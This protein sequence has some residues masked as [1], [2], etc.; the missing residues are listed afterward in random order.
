MNR[1]PVPIESVAA[2]LMIADCS[3]EVA[4]E[5][6]TIPPGQT[7]TFVSG[8]STIV[9]GG[10]AT[11][12]PRDE[13]AYLSAVR[14]EGGV[15]STATDTDLLGAGQSACDHLDQGIDDEDIARDLAGSVLPRGGDDAVAIV[16]AASL[17][18]CG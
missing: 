6:I 1:S 11:P 8:D 18:L 10:D 4:S 17:S 15:L 9:V 7:G 16:E 5:S 14:N 12:A 3:S 2:L 13:V